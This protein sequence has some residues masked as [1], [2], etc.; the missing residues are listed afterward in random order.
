MGLKTCVHFGVGKGSGGG[1]CR[2]ARRGSAAM[3]AGDPA[4]QV[5]E[6]AMEADRP[7][8]GWT[9]PPRGRYGRTGAPG[10]GGAGPKRLRPRLVRGH[11]LVRC[12][13]ARGRRRDCSSHAGL[14]NFPPVPRR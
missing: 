10:G 3:A 9:R 2:Q 4:G 5:E 7:C 13:A 6:T 14:M 8:M 1:A 11:R 12:G